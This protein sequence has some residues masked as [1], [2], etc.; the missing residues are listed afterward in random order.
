MPNKIKSNQLDFIIKI[1]AGCFIFVLAIFL[2][3][4]VS[5]H[6]QAAES[7]ITAGLTAVGEQ[8]ILTAQDPRVIIGNIIKIALGFVGAIAIIIVMYAG[9]LYMTSGGEPAKVEKAKKWMINGAIGL[10]IIF[11][12]YAIVSFVVNRL[13]GAGGGGGGVTIAGRGGPGVSLSGGAFGSVIQSHYPLPEQTGVPRN[14]MILVT[15]RLPVDPAS[16]I[17][18]ANAAY[19]CPAMADGRICGSLTESFKVFGCA[20]EKMMDC[21]EVPGNAELQVPGYAMITADHRTIIFNPYG[22]SANEHMGS[23][24][25][26]VSYIVQL[27]SGILREGSDGQSIFNLATPDYKWRFL[28][29]TTIDNIPPQIRSVVPADHEYPDVSDRALDKQGYV[30]LNQIVS[31]NFN[32]PV[33]PPLSQ[34]QVCN[35]ADNDNEAQLFGPDHAKDDCETNHIP[36]D[37]KVGINSYKTIQ[38]ISNTPCEGVQENSCG[39][40][41]FCLPSNVEITG[42]ALAADLIEGCLGTPGTGIMDMAGNSLDGNANDKCDGPLTDD[43]QWKF[44][45]GDSLDLTPPWITLLEPNN[46]SDSLPV[47]VILSATFNEGLDA[48]S[49]D[50]EVALI[51]EDFTSWF[52]AN[53]G[54]TADGEVDD[55]KIEINHG[56]FSPET[57][58]ASPKYTPIIKSTVRDSRQNCFSPTKS[59]ADCTDAGSGT[60][61]CPNLNEANFPLQ[62]VSADSCPLPSAE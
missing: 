20:E 10:V 45:T 29:N 30:Y 57:A 37:W 59:F 11:S 62:K 5:V 8:T 53:L 13:V 58:N 38:F 14:S 3:S 43:F 28:T 34:E 27:T 16:V 1:T 39:E 22:Q 19:P 18:S 41:V 15:F 49:V 7:E 33:I 51:G 56:A 42:K 47:N 26:E 50:R 25:N 40:P 35:A 46:A 52:D 44:K 31:I 36:G 17:G 55:A 24:E 48:E 21:K 32:E 9:A 2:F 4:P 23:S 61:C 12:A 6:A 60:S 54:E